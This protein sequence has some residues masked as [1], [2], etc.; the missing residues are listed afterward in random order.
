MKKKRNH[1]NSFGNWIKPRGIQGQIRKLMVNNQEYKHQN[2]IQNELL[3]SCETLVRNTSENTSENCK[4]FVNVV[5]LP[6]LNYQE[7]RICQGDLDET[8]LMK[9]LK[10]IQNKKSPGNDG[11]T[12]EFCETCWD[13]IKNP[14]MNLIM[15]A[16]EKK[17]IKYFS[18]SSPNYANRTERKEI[19]EF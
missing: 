3:F 5:S 2:K 18:K 14:S 8:E 16:R 1:R 12:K 7:A 15:E 13:E 10:S 9:T 6:K 19:N 17:E 11:L 4:R